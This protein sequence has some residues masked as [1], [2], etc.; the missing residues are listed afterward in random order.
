MGVSVNCIYL[1]G[2]RLIFQVT[3]TPS[4]RTETRLLIKSAN[5]VTVPAPLAS[6]IEIFHTL[7][8]KLFCEIVQNI[9]II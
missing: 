1:K 5:K 6:L 3:Y 7:E 9:K 8:G 2:T 4:R